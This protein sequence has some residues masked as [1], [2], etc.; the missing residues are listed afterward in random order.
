[1]GQEPNAAA[2]A[3]PRPGSRTAVPSEISGAGSVAA[4][5]SALQHQAFLIGVRPAGQAAE[6]CSS[7]LVAVLPDQGGL[8][9]DSFDGAP[10]PGAMLELTASV[11]GA[12]FRMQARLTGHTRHGGL[13]CLQLSLP[14]RVHWS[15]RRRH[16]RVALGPAQAVEVHLLTASRGRVVAE[17]GDISVTGLSLR[18]APGQDTGLRA[19]DVVP[20]CTVKLPGAE[21]LC[22]AIEICH[23]SPAQG[24]G[25]PRLGARFLDLQEDDLL[26]LERFVL[27]RLPP[28][29]G[30]TG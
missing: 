19:G 22:C 25:S 30:N 5:L 16:Q 6:P 2:P 29:A 21:P 23:L 11:P 28:E 18:L 9:I 4:R 7:A 15:Q 20:R 14:E 1:M 3:R 13:D 8:L 26:R 12:R 27:E 17:L 10:E 24:A